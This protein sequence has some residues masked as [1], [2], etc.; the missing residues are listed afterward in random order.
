M[1]VHAN[2]EHRP[3]QA[4]LVTGASSGIGEAITLD[5]V[6]RGY[7][8]FAGVRSE[9]AA[10]ELRRKVHEDPVGLRTTNGGASGRGAAECGAI[11][12]VQLDVTK[13]EQV[14][15]VAAAVAASSDLNLLGI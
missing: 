10:A 13:D 7:R 4:V 14:A 3:Q 1:S 15:A 11:E 2:G 9:S 5:L 12:P 6:R 8:V